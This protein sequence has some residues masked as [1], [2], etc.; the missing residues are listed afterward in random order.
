MA[1]LCLK[2]ISSLLCKGG[3]EAPSWSDSIKWAPFDMDVDMW[4]RGMES[5]ARLFSQ[6]FTPTDGVSAMSP[7]API[8]RRSPTHVWDR[9]PCFRGI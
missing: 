2:L 9:Q 4:P 6:D 1:G 7:D 3:G 5:R 8:F